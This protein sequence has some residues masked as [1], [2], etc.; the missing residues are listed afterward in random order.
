MSRTRQ[1]SRSACAPDCKLKPKTLKQNRQQTSGGIAPQTKT[2]DPAVGAMPPT[3]ASDPAKGR[4]N[5]TAA[6]VSGSFKRIVSSVLHSEN[7]NLLNCLTSKVSHEPDRTKT[8]YGKTKY[9]IENGRL[10]LVAL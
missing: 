4:L 5:F 7:N 1:P 9:H 10:R 8:I 3:R 6:S 2:V